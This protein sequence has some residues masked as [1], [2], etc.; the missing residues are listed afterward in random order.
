MT[1]S[2]I[3]TKQWLKIKS[4]IVNTNNWLNEKFPSFNSLNKEI[5]PGFCLVDIFSDCF[6][7]LF[8]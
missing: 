7:F 6:S 8:S 3:T 2:Y 1:I 4:S 5:S